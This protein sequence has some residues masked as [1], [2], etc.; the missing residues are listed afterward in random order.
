MNEKQQ[1][2]FDPVARDMAQEALDRV[3]EH[4]RR[5]TGLWSGAFIALLVVILGWLI[6]R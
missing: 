2:Q 1:H 5:C 4:E 3:Q 6:A